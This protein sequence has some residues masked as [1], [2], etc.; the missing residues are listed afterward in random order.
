MLQARTKVACRIAQIEPQKLNEAVH[1]GHLPCAPETRPGVPRVFD[2]DAL[3]MLR[4]YAHLMRGG[5]TSERA[6]LIACVL[7]NRFRVY[8][9]RYT[10]HV[11]TEACYVQYGEGDACAYCAPVETMDDYAIAGR[12]AIFTVSF[13][14]ARERA[15]VAEL[16]EAEAR[17]VGAE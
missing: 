3:V 1:F 9:G 15:L 10:D 2:V 14:I 5:F 17:I 4:I 6:G 8:D 12:T 7:Y 13:D 11:A 16:L